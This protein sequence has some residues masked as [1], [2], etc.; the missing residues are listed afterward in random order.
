MALTATTLS[1]AITAT[2]T[3]FTLASGT[4]IVVPNFTA[5]PPAPLLELLATC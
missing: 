1:A 4:G 5:T 2:Q 3:T